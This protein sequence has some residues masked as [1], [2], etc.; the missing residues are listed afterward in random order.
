MKKLLLIVFS[1]AMIAGVYAEPPHHHPHRRMS[2]SEIN[3]RRLERQEESIQRG[4]EQSE[5]FAAR[6]LQMIENSMIGNAGTGD[7]HRDNSYIALV[8]ATKDPYLIYDRSQLMFRVF[9]KDGVLCSFGD[10]NLFI[11]MYA[12]EFENYEEFCDL[13]RAKY[14]IDAIPSEEEFEKA[15]VFYATEDKVYINNIPE[16]IERK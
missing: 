1:V 16:Y 7:G 9:L 10:E 15:Y 4:F 2:A 12:D 6:V 11:F 3:Q 14:W 13:I 8:N 5:R